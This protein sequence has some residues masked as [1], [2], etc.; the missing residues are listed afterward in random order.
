M[1]CK[2]SEPAFSTNGVQVLRLEKEI[3]QALPSQALSDIAHSLEDIFGTP[4][5]PRFPA[6]GITSVL[7]LANLKRAAGPVSSDE[8]DTQFG[9]YRKHCVRCHGLTGDGRGAAARMLAPYPRD[10]R[11]GK[12]KF[13]STP[14]GT[15]PTRADLARTL[16]QGIPGTSMPAFDLL[17]GEDIEALVDYVIYLSVRGQTERALLDEIAYNSDSQADTVATDKIV[18]RL[19]TQWRVPSQPESEPPAGWVAWGQAAKG[20]EEQSRLSQ[21]VERGRQLFQS[22]LAGCAKC[23]GETGAGGRWQGDFDDWTKDWTSATGIHTTDKASL[24]PFFRAGAFK[25]ISNSA[26]DLTLGVFRGGARPADL[27]NRIVH[28][29]E[30]TP[31]PAAAVQPSVPQGLTTEQVW[32]VVNYLLSLTKSTPHVT[33]DAPTQAARQNPDE[34]LSQE[35]TL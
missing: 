8:E 5:D 21:S 10:F 23:H 20:S 14:I 26:R 28:G 29:I 1:G 33:S 15:K 2:R 34:H 31:M 25:P 3:G 11:M 27:Y 22:E 35:T 16:R 7:S 6:E 24:K 4:N 18:A 13:K 12:F 32:D 19:L 17:K 9:L 30:G